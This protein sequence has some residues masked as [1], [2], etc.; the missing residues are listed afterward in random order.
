MSTMDDAAFG[1][2]LQFFRLSWQG[3]R[4]VRKG[5]KKRVAS[6]MQS[7]N[8]RTVDEYLATLDNHPEELQRAVELLTVSISRF[9]RDRRLWEVLQERL[10]P[11]LLDS[12]SCSVRVWSAGC[13]CGEEVYSLKILWE[14]LKKRRAPLPP[15]E[16]WATDVNPLMIEKARRAVYPPSSLRELSSELRDEYFV[17]FRQAFVVRPDL[18]Q[19]IHWLLRDLTKDDPPETSL[20]LIFLRNNLLTYYEPTISHPVFLKIVAALRWGGTL[21]IGHKEQMPSMDTPLQSCPD[22]H[23]VFIKSLTLGGNQHQRCFAA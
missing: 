9:F 19:G 16:I 20:D 6:H 2:I 5:V 23:G 12:A 8:C 22:Y 3:Y 21:I 13:A 18:Q 4:K 15:V 14:E 10:V 11:K 7:T 17:P 1:K